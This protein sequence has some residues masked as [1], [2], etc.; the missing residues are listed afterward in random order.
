MAIGE[1]RVVL[2]MALASLSE[3]FLVPLRSALLALLNTHDVLASQL[4]AKLAPLFGAL[5]LALS[6][7]SLAS[8]LD[9]KFAPL[10]G[11]LALALSED[12]LDSL[13]ACTILASLAKAPLVGALALTSQPGVARASSLEA[14]GEELL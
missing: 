11:A 7:G 10:S 8:L 1:A 14:K 9:A 5:A 12:S 13:S 4:E 3:A 6:K 2:Q